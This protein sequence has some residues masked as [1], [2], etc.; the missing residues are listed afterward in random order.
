VLNQ[1][2]T[3]APLPVPGPVQ[4]IIAP[5][6]S[7]DYSAAV[8][9]AAFRA[10]S[11]NVYDRIVLLADADVARFEGVALPDVEA[12]G[13]PLG[14]VPVDREAVE[15]LLAAPGFRMHAAG[16]DDEYEIENQLPWIRK[17]FPQAR[18]IPVVIGRVPLDSHAT[19]TK[20]LRP[21]LGDR[22]LLVV[23]TVLGAA[24][25]AFG[26]TPPGWSAESRPAFEEESR[27]YDAETLN[28]IVG[29]RRD[30]LVG[31]LQQTRV[32]ACSPTSLD[33]MLSLLQPGEGSIV[34]YDTSATYER[35][36][37]IDIDGIVGYGAVVF[38]AQG[39]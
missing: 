37:K 8:A 25:P 12:F 9:A 19:L 28:L 33:L 38:R 29:R 26:T 39:R 16:F 31:R 32:T 18:M 21:L 30:E 17:L 35:A 5:H 11:A 1:L 22:T 6:A 7:F 15:Q 2:L 27:R 4:A 13:T 24:G 34:A 14:A 10:A 36:A 3:R 20:A 23:S